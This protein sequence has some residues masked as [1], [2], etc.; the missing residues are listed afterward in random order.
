[1]TNITKKYACNSEVETVEF[2]PV[3]AIGNEK[4]WDSD[5][6]YARTCL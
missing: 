4:M 5:K 2:Y 6:Y 3:Y 1:M